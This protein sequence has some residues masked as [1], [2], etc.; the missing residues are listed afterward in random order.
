MDLTGAERLYNPYE[1][2]STA[3]D[4]RAGLP[5][6]LYRLPEQPEFLFS[7]EASVHKRS[8]S[9]NLTYYTGLGY[10]SGTV[11]TA[12]CQHFQLPKQ[13]IIQHA[14]CQAHWASGE[15]SVYAGAAVGGSQGLL[16]AVRTR[17]EIPINSSR[18][19]VNRVLNLSGGAGR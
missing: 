8:W 17:P 3:L 14:A 12:L 11:H 19:K 7:E 4:A 9:E 16:T 2:L 6:N 5:R 18:L 1:G 13:F 10:L 15:E